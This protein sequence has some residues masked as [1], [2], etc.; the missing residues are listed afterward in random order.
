MKASAAATARQ[1]ELIKPPGALGRLEDIAI[2][3]AGWQG[4]EKPVLENVRAVVFAGNHGVTAQGISAFP[5]EVT[6][7][8]VRSFEA[9]KAGINALAEVA[10]LD[11]H[12]LP[13]ELD[14]PTQDFT[15]HPAMTE[16]ECLSA[17]SA[18]ASMVKKNLHLFIPGEMGIGNTTV[19]AALCA[20]VFGGDGT[21]WA[22][23]GSGLGSS[24]VSLKAT[25][26]DQ[27]I[28]CHKDASA[29]AF[30]TLRRL[31]GRELAAMAGAVLQARMLR[32]PVVLDGFISCAAIAPLFM[33]NPAILDHCLAG[34]CSAEP[35][36]ESLL[37]K[38][39]LTPLLNLGMRLG[40]G[41]GAVAAV[42]LIRAALHTHSQ[43]ATFAEAGV[44]EKL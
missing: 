18:G 41:S 28:D 19:A 3:M 40:E 11:L 37:Q 16:E 20:R 14:H 42:P 34:H 33:E 24:G 38:F 22:G 9:G 5:P 15:A 1:A 4:R 36:H 10:G 13:L 44:A 30:E 2:F 23:P 7:E 35:G 26:I 27:A 21:E 31:G 6:K 43:M 12:V 8:M 29:S 39:G 17:L 25:V 32:V